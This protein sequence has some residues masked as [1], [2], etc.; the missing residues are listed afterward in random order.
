M[1]TDTESLNLSHSAYKVCDMVT[2][3]QQSSSVT[4]QLVTA[5]TRGGLNA[6]CPVSAS[7]TIFL[8]DV[9]IHIP[10]MLHT[11]MDTVIN[12]VSK[13]DYRFAL[14]LSL[15]ASLACFTLIYGQLW[16]ASH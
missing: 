6:Q 1:V 9:T 10:S 15:S 2:L 5:L 4:R 13:A 12:T 8:R 16:H 7:S 11:T 3:G 14:L